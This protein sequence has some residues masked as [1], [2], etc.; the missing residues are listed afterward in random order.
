MHGT[1][2]GSEIDKELFVQFV[3]YNGCVSSRANFL[4]GVS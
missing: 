2:L 4:C 1:W 3:G